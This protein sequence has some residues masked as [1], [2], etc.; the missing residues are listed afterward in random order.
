MKLEEEGPHNITAQI[1]DMRQLL[2]FLKLMLSRIFKRSRSIHSGCKVVEMYPPA[3]NTRHD[4]RSKH[5]PPKGNSVLTFMKTHD[6][7]GST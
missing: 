4:N 6:S 7:L 3:V 5:S 2:V 1:I